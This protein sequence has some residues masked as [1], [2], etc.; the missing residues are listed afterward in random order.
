MF[1]F[2]YKNYEFKIQI[3]NNFGILINIDKNTLTDKINMVK[4]IMSENEILKIDDLPEDLDLTIKEN[5]KKFL[6]YIGSNLGNHIQ[7]LLKKN[8]ASSK[9]TLEKFNVVI[10]C[11]IDINNDKFELLLK[12]TNKDEKIESKTDIQL[13]TRDKIAQINTVNY[14]KLLV[15]F[16]KNGDLEEFEKQINLNFAD[17]I[18][19]LMKF[20]FNTKKEIIKQKNKEEKINLIS[21]EYKESKNEKLK[22]D[23]QLELL[24]EKLQN[25]EKKIV[26]LNNKLILYKIG[27]GLSI[28]FLIVIIILFFKKSN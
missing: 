2:N 14:K 24:N 3:T 13:I 16:S 17:D 22:L 26:E 12:I 18:Q 19:K 7:S 21:S 10:A 5:E 27:S 4:I 8:E 11:K 9:F 20:V 28:V 15:E 25:S 1:I 6:T 23:E